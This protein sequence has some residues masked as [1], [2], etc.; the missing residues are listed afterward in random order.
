MYKKASKIKLKFQ[1][2]VG[3][4]GVEDL[5]DL[6]VKILDTEY[7]KLNKELKLTEE[8]SLLKVQSSK[9]TLLN[10]KM[11]IIKDIVEDK[12]AQIDKQRL[13]AEN[14][15]KREKLMGILAGKEDE[16]LRSMSAEEIKAELAALEQ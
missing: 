3:T 6:D 11:S 12:L 7:K 4:I 8:E 1:T 13:A 10:L 5:W 14:K 15:A 16:G 2:S 9:N